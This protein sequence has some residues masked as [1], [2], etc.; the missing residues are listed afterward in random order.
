VRTLNKVLIGIGIFLCL[1]VILLLLFSVLIFYFAFI[2][3]SKLEKKGFIL[4]KLKPYQEQIDNGTRWF[5]TQNYQDVSL[6]SFDNLTL[7]ARL[8]KNPKAIGTIIL[9]HGHRGSS[10][11]DFSCVFQYYYNL[12]YNI[13]IPEQRAHGRSQGKFITWGIKEKYDCLAWIE[14]V[15]QEFD[16]NLPIFLSGVSMGASTVLMALS[17]PLPANVKGI[18]SDCGFTSP[19]R[20]L[21]NI[22]NSLF[23]PAIPVLLVVA[24]YAK[25]FIGIDIRKESTLEAMKT[26]N[27]PILFIHGADDTLVPSWM[28]VENF[29]AYQN[30]KE[31]YVIDHADHGMSYLVAKEKC[32]QVLKVFLNKYQ[33]K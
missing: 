13:L 2:R 28:S 18:I 30:N 9:V 19:Y 17:L 26:G 29:N 5:L 14:F 27:I 11:R 10:L 33:K 23:I 7:F 20:L 16:S 24:Y 4:K 32:E 21:K 8:L 3:S 1:F 25:V 12:G 31:L 22:L 6:T 15:N